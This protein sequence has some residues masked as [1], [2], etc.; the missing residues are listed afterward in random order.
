MSPRMRCA[1]AFE[2]FLLI[3][4]AAA[5]PRS[6]MPGAKHRRPTATAAGIIASRRNS[7]STVALL[8]SDPR[9]VRRPRRFNDA[10]ISLAERPWSCNDLTSGKTG[11][12]AMLGPRRPL[13]AG[14]VGTNALYTLWHGRPDPR[15]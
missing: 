10:A 11:R 15:R 6:R 2:R 7:A 12:Y 5:T 13:N 1:C 9:C 8:Q 14:E 4:A 3:A